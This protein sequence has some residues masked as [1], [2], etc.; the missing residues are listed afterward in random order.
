MKGLA[1]VARTG[2]D[3]VMRNPLRS[4]AVVTCIAAVLTPFVAGLGISRGLADQAETAVAFGPDIHVTGERLGREV[5]IPI[6]A[7]AMV[8]DVP[9][10]TGVVP[11]IVA[12]IRLG[13]GSR[14]AVLVGLPAAQFPV[15]AVSC[16]DGRLPAAG[17]TNELAVGSQ[18]ARQLDL[19][20]GATIPP[21]YRNDREGERLSLVVGVFRSDL[22]VWEA[23]LV[24]ADLETAARIVDARGLVSD[25]LVSCPREYRRAVRAKIMQLGSLAP[26]DPQGPIR[27]SVLTREEALA[28]LPE[29]VLERERLFNLHF[30]LA[31]AV[32]IL[33]LMV[34]SGV[35]L[36]ER[37]HETG[38]LKALGWQTDEILVRGL[39]ESAVLAAIG[40][41]LAVLL[42]FA[43]LGLMN[44]RGIA[45]AF[46]A[47]ADFAPGFDVPFRLAPEPILIAYV[48]SFVVTSVGSLLSTWRAATASP[49]DALA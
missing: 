13:A 36:S 30:V 26:D 34:T 16:V 1:A 28:M 8:S 46:I 37:R 17:T 9:G 32:A 11:R 3:A 18:L 2:L 31:F 5:P 29:G 23:S 6:A 45:S 7:A 43:W 24:L 22:P 10:V 20:V 41:S 35:G 15:A 44:G 12:A 14:P 25:L 42:A 48:L 40:A 4:W 47:G 49:M 27:P 38:I 19:D 33:A 39:V 21:F